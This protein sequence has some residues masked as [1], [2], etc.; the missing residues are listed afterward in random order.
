MHSKTFSGLRVKDEARGLV[1]ATFATLNVVDADGDIT[2]PGA[3]DGNKA[4]AFAEGHNQIIGRGTIREEG[5]KA[6]FEGECF[7]D[8]AAGREAFTRIAKLADVMEYSYGFRVEKSRRGETADGR[9]VRFL[10]K[11]AVKEVSAVL[12]GAGV[13]TGTVSTKEE[14][15]M[16]ENL[17]L[18]CAAVCEVTGAACAECAAAHP[19]MKDACEACAAACA[20]CVAALAAPKG[21][22][23][24]DPEKAKPHVHKDLSDPA[25]LGPLCDACAGLCGVTAAEVPEA[26]AACE[27]CAAACGA[28]SEAMAGAGEGEA[29]GGEPMPKE[30]KMGDTEKKIIEGLQAKNLDLQKRLDERDAREK[31]AYLADLRQHVAARGDPSDPV[32]TKALRA[33]EDRWAAD[34]AGA[35]ILGDMLRK[36]ASQAVA[37]QVIEQPSAQPAERKGRGDALAAG[38]ISQGWE[39]KADA[40]GTV[41]ASK[42]INGRKVE[43]TY[44][45]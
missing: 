37:G 42:T 32:V 9:H 25:A 10:E 4:V 20:A 19:E 23:A 41:T 13:G 33:I 6:I 21:E 35:E 34:R 40:Q 26:K 2:L 24:E 39:A 11:V 12:A 36:A 18:A 43:K 29:A 1:T 8:T 30:A 27:A 3:F 28:C 44:A 14:K 7:M 15:A 22:K 38:L 16:P 45:A 17:G 31:A 5:D